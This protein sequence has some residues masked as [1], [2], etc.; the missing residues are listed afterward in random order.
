MDEYR[1]STHRL[2]SVLT[3]FV[4]DELIA[5]EGE[6]ALGEDEELL[7]SGGLDSLSVM[8][9]VTFIE[10]D[11]HVTVPLA[12]LTAENFRSITALSSYLRTRLPQPDR[13]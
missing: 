13:Q 5:G 4:N 3:R 10:S 2:E 7:G 6:G 11:L 9:L 12:D 8:R 1:M